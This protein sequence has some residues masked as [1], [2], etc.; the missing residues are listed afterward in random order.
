[1]LLSPNETL[2]HPCTNLK[3]LDRVTSEVFNQRLKTVR[4]CY[5]A[6]MYSE[7]LESLGIT[8]STRPENLSLEQFV[9]MAN[10]LDANHSH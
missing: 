6:L 8:P 7:T 9:P 2:P 4:N 1:V 10:W 5:K 3:W